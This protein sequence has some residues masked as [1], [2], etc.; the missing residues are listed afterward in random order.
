MLH[1]AKGFNDQIRLIGQPVIVY[2]FTDTSQRVATHLALASVR[3][4]HAHTEVPLIRRAD[5]HHA[6]RADREMA[7][8]HKSCQLR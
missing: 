6:I 7:V 8:A 4:E 1:P 3:V 5:Q 2:I